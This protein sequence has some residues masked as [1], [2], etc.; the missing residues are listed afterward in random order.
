M[1]PVGL[2]GRM[3]RGPL[4]AVLAAAV[5]FGSAGLARADEIDRELDFATALARFGLPY[6]GSRVVERLLVAHPDAAERAKPVKAELMLASGRLK[7]AEEAVKALSASDKRTQGM[8]LTLANAFYNAG[9][10]DK[11][12][13]L[14]DDFFKRVQGQPADPAFYKTAAFQYGQILEHAGDPAGAFKA[15]QYVVDLGTRDEAGRQALCE[16]AELCLKLADSA[17]GTNSVNYLKQSEKLANTV[18]YQGL[19][20]WYGRALITLASA[21]ERQGKLVDAQHVL[22][23]GMK[24]LTEIE[25]GIREEAGPNSAAAVMQIS[26]IPGARA[27]LG[28]LHVHEGKDFLNAGQK[29]KAKAAFGAALTE[30]VNVLKKYPKSPAA[31]DV[32]ARTQDLLATLQGMGSKVSLDLTPWLA[33]VNAPVFEPADELFRAGK[34]D[35]ALENYEKLLKQFGS[36][37]G[38]PQALANMMMCRARLQQPGKALAAANDLAARFAADPRAPAG[39]LQLAK[40]YD[41]QGADGEAAAVKIY[42]LYLKLFP[43]HERAPNV[44]YRLAFLRN[45]AKEPEAAVKLLQRIADD[46]PNDPLGAKAAS[47][48]AWSYYAASNYDL[49]IKGFTNYLVAAQPSP[50]KAQAQFFLAT[51]F[52]MSGRPREALGAFDELASWLQKDRSAY[53]RVPADLK[54]NDDLLEQAFFLR[55]TCLAAIKE[56]A[57]DVGPSR[58]KA[59]KAFDEF[60]QRYPASKQLSKALRTKG[61]VY[62]ELGRLKDAAQVFDELAAKYP[63]TEEGKSAL[64]ALAKSALEVRQIKQAQDALAK[65]ITT[66]DKFGP[67]IFLSLGKDFSDAKLPADAVK[68]F[69]TALQKLADPKAPLREVAI[70]AKGKAQHDAGDAAGAVQTLTQLFKDYPSTGFYRDGKFVLADAAS[71]L[72]QFALAETALGDVMRQFADKPVIRNQADLELARLQLATGKKEVALSSFQ[73]VALLNDPTNA[74]LAPLIEEAFREAVRVGMDLRLY[75]DVITNCEQYEKSFPQGKYL[76]ETRKARVEAKTKTSGG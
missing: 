24:I 58:E 2:F 10:F 5:A 63:N 27:A 21:R 9:Q 66:A 45:Q 61:A 12:R 8:L 33:Q 55:G 57:A 32:A 23:N 67:E 68:C 43:K 59:I 65:L 20:M 28:D 75:A 30:Y 38:V 18:L 74:D 19:D 39:L 46:F 15:Y 14:Y 16:Q 4:W 6:Y 54:K 40:Y 64:Y 22:M 62:L 13:S 70:Y 53:A 69:D 25:R 56:P 41:D 73:R 52:R 47:Q 60:A 1:K 44:L 3:A 35:K 72:K 49:A 34:Y 26:P 71:Q 11:T 50:D 7:E 37:P 42:N 76:D 51:A 36:N 48:L 29:D 17:T 31:S